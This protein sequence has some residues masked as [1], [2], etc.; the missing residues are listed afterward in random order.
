MGKKKSFGQAANEIK[1]VHEQLCTAFPERGQ[2]ITGSLTALLAGEHVLMLGP[3]GTA[4]SLFART[5]SSATAGD[6][7]FEVLLTKFT[8]VEEVFGPVSFKGLKEDRFERILDGYAAS[9][10]VVFL[11]EIFKSSSAILNCLLTL[12]NERVVHNGGKPIAT[13][14]E[15]IF[16]ASNEYPQDESLKALF[17][18]FSF[19]FWVDYIGDKDALKNV[20]MAGGIGDFK[21][22]IGKGAME[23]LRSAVSDFE[24]TRGNVDTLIRIKAAVENEGFVASDRSWVKARKIV[25]AR[26]VL[27]GR[28]K[29]ASSDWMILSNCLWQE[30]KDRDRLHGIIGNAADPYGSRAEAIRDAITTSMRALPSMSLL[31]SGSKKKTEMVKDITA[32]SHEVTSRRD[33]FLEMVDESGSAEGDFPETKTVVDAAMKQI[34]DLLSKVTFFRAPRSV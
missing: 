15:M 3:P 34:Q 16:A 18:R 23:V 27:A 12:M 33:A 6:S 7:F 9:R 26:A 19:K 4:K 22:S 14:L 20:I 2:L 31:Q 28:D 24:F 10:S 1:E 17:D 21:A 13:P 11:D 25:C 30:H 5:L 32:V 8:A 29:V